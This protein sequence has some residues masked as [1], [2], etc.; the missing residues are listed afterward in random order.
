MERC[1]ADWRARYGPASMR[2][3]HLI[4]QAMMNEEGFAAQM[5]K[6]GIQD[7]QDYIL[8]QIAQIPNASHIDVHEGGWNSDWKARYQKTR[9]LLVKIWN[10]KQNL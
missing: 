10:K 7:P 8:R 4:P 6:A 5:K 3:H 9:H 2:E 1:S